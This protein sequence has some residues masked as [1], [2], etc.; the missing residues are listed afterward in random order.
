[1]SRISSDT[2]FHFTPTLENLVSILVNEFRPRLCMEDFGYAAQ[3]LHDDDVEPECGIPMVSLRDIPLS[4]VA[5]HMAVTSNPF[6]G[7]LATPEPLDVEPN[8]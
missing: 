8:A 4:Q 1:M 7:F 3:Y 5:A 6:K 2:L